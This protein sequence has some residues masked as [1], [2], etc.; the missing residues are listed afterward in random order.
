MQKK[1][2]FYFDLIFFHFQKWWI[3]VDT[4]PYIVQPVQKVMENGGAMENVNGKMDNAYTLIV[5]ILLLLC[6]I[7]H[8]SIQILHCT[9]ILPYIVQPVQKVMEN[10]GAMENVN[11]K[12]DNAYTLIVSTVFP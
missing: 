12:M 4:L 11:G 6:T 8:F 5:S 9:T 7:V 2:R 10:G 1:T 3:A